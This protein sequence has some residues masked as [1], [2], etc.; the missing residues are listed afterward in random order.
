MSG[1]ILRLCSRQ[2]SIDAHLPELMD[3]SC[4]FSTHCIRPFRQF[5]QSSKKESSRKEEKCTRIVHFCGL[6]PP[7]S[8]RGQQEEGGLEKLS[9]DAG[10]RKSADTK[11]IN[12]TPF[13]IPVVGNRLGKFYR[14]GF[15][16]VNYGC[17]FSC[18]WI[19][20]FTGWKIQ[21]YANAVV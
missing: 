10:S 12:F 2:Q 7:S 14:G 17:F 13:S 15:F 5:C 4:N 6:S 1:E 11:S 3:C 21:E 16:R 9:G 8:L 18:G 20:T 19:A